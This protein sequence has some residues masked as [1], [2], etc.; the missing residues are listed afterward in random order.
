MFHFGS[1]SSSE[2]ETQINTKINKKQIKNS[3]NLEGNIE[4]IS[5]SSADE[6]L[7]KLKG[8]SKAK[9]NKGKMV[10]KSNANK[11]QKF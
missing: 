3:T 9:I 10:M 8:T 2:S 11:Y 4:E 6:A 1:D 7:I 5:D